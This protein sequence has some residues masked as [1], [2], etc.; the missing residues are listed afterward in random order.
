[1]A[2]DETIDNHILDRFTVQQ[3]L[4]KGAY[5][6]VWRVEERSTGYTYALKKIFGAFQVRTSELFLTC[7]T[8]QTHKEPTEK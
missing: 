3:K 5:G 8:P 7:R 1:M 2:E 4:G 6:V